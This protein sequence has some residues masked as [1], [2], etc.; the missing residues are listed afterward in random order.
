MS[1]LNI[2]FLLPSIRDQ[3]LRVELSFHLSNRRLPARECRNLESHASPECVRRQCVNDLNGGM[4][5]SINQ[6]IDQ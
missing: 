2:V 6:S 5:E 3:W 1:E 4:I